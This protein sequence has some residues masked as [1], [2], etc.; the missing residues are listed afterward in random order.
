ME[1]IALN[2]ESKSSKSLASFTNT[3][4][5]KITKNLEKFHYN[6]IIANFHEA[7]NFLN[8]EIEKPINNFELTENY[9]KILCLLQPVIPH[10]TLECL[11]E[12]DQKYNPKWPVADF[13][14]IEKETLNIVIQIEGKKRGV[15]LSEADTTEEQLIIRI[16]KDNI[17]NKFV[18]GKKIKKSIYI[19]NKLINLIIE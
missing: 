14:L 6:V 13:N 15:L 10:F 16:K 5:D 7:Y 8:K 3:L 1:K 4:I 9:K 17:I 2:E 12:M 18:K 11:E 19:K